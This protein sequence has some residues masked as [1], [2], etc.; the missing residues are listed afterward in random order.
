MIIGISGNNG[1]GKDTLG[2]LLHAEIERL[3]RHAR[4]AAFADALYFVCSYLFGTPS[5]KSADA[6]PALKDA[7]IR[8]R[9]VRDYLIEVGRAMRGI[10]YDVWVRLVQRQGL[11]II[12]DVR[13]EN[14][15]NICDRMYQV[16]RNGHDENVGLCVGEVIENNGTLDDLAAKA[17]EIAH[18]MLSEGILDSVGN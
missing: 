1:A 10:D 14:E 11:T 5:K 15:V 13:F 2:A 9:R 8:D 12:T 7:I 4:R 16:V 18:A 3:G 17:K 6:N